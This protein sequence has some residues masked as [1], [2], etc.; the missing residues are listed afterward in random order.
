M[1]LSIIVPAY[2][3]EKRIVPFI[4]SLL[5]FSKGL[6]DYEIIFVNDG[7]RDNTLG[8]IRSFTK[9]NK[10]VKIISYVHNK[11]KAGA[12][13]EGVKLASGDKILFIDA[14]GSIP[15]HEIK[16]MVAKLDDYDVVVGDRHSKKSKIDQSVLRL[17]TGNCFNAYV[18]LLFRLNV[19]D[20]LC[21]FKGFRKK[22]AK[23]LFGEL[24]SKRWIFDVELFYRIKRHGYSIY[25]LP[26]RWINKKGSKIGIFDPLKMALQL[27]DLRKKLKAEEKKIK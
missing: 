5:E 3:E 24:I 27:L 15:P 23:K 19:P 25:F 22:I 2:N 12:L 13:K 17:F 7:S 9:G 26:V 8:V 20:N 1:K 6:R 4:A 18:N 14:D 21:G 10:N 11:G 16:N